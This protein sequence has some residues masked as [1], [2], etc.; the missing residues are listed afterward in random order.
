[1]PLIESKQLRALAVTSAQRSPSVP[2][3]P[4]TIETG[5]PNSEYVFWIGAFAP[6]VVPRDIVQRLHAGITEALADPDV[7]NGMKKLAAE[8][9]PLT[10]EKFN[11]FI[12]RVRD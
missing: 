2:D 10:P 5:F 7:Q 11:D 8:P 4:T 1:M 3:I 12:N 9:M 6:A